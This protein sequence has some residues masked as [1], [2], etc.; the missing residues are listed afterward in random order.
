MAFSGIQ[1]PDVAAMVG[2][3]MRDVVSK[4]DFLRARFF[5]QPHDIL[6]KGKSVFSSDH[7]V[8]IMSIDVTDER[9]VATHPIEGKSSVQDHVYR[10]Q[11]TAT[12][13]ILVP[14]VDYELYVGQQV[15]TMFDNVNEYTIKSDGV[16]HDNMLII[17]K[18]TKRNTDMMDVISVTLKFS[19]IMKSTVKREDVKKSSDADYARTSKRGQINPG[20]EV[21]P[22][23]K[24]QV[25]INRGVPNA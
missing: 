13:E 21:T 10:V 3:K 7:N 20:S 5:T 11:K 4:S 15:K 25:I 17:G 23:L 18:P 16:L 19:E 8:S 2:G 1:I 24:Q 12:V 14:V 6:L 22:E 9:E